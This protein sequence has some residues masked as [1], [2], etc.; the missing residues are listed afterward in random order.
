MEREG[1]I[2][3]STNAWASPIVLVRKKMAVSVSA[4]YR[5]LNTITTKD[6]YPLPHIDDTLD[7]IA[8]STWF[9]TLDLKSAYWQVEM[10]P[11]DKEKIALVAG[12]G[13]WQFT[14]MPFG[15]CN[16]HATFECLV[17]R[18]L[19]GLPLTVCLLY[20]DD[21]L[22]HAKNFQIELDHLTIKKGT[23]S[24]SCPGLSLSR[25]PLYFV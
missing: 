6:F 15:L 21:T 22:V 1:V 7:A 24:D 10:D 4:D 19:D 11:V 2:E 3:P 8:G 12:Q 16:A 5:K 14:V 20:L 17:E 23:I 13:Q 9:S 18:V 25:L